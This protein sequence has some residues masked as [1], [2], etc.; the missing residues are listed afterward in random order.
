MIA[1]G[2]SDIEFEIG[3]AYTRPSIMSAGCARY[4]FANPQA[5]GR[6]DGHLQIMI[7]SG[8]AHWTTGPVDAE[9]SVTVG[10]EAS[11]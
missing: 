6:S 1:G 7:L 3:R 11:A 4:E 9:R 2:A 5:A 10:G 8:V